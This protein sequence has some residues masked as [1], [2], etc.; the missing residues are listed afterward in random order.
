MAR[1]RQA[2]FILIDSLLAIAE[3]KPNFEGEA[4]NVGAK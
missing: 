1:K 2:K 3:V 4:L